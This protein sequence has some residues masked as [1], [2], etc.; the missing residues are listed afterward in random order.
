M[1]RARTRAPKELAEEEVI[2][3]G[4]REPLRAPRRG[5]DDVHVLGA[6]PALAND[7]QRIR[8]SAEGKGRGHGWTKHGRLLRGKGANS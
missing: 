7:A 4:E 8:T 6:E 3:P 5:G 2:E 1:Q